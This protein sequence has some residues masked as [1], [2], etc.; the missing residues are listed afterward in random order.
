MKMI[1]TLTIL[2]IMPICSWAVRDTKGVGNGGFAYKNAITLLNAAQNDLSEWLFKL[3]E[4]CINSKLS[5]HGLSPVS[6]RRLG[7]AIKN[8][9]SSYQKNKNSINPSG[10]TLPLMFTYGTS[11]EGIEH[12]EALQPFFVAYMSNAYTRNI[13][14]KNIYHNGSVIMRRRLAEGVFAEVQGLLLHEASH[15]FKYSELDA[16]KFAREMM[17]IK[18]SKD[19]YNYKHL[20]F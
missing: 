6:T 10:D 16:E 18:F 19:E 9:K 12:I 5:P 1:T 15:I 2:L 3:N 7:Q 14:Q 8:M 17:S 11:K 20:C 4:G 13:N